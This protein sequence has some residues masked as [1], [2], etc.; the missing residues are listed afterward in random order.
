MAIVADI[1]GNSKQD[2]AV[3]AKNLTSKAPVDFTGRRIFHWSDSFASQE[4]G[5]DSTGN[6]KVP[7]GLAV[8]MEMLSRGKF[9]ADYDNI[10]G[11]MGENS[12]SCR[13]RFYT[14]VVTRKNNIDIVLIDT[15]RNDPANSKSDGDATVANILAMVKLVQSIGKEPWVITPNPPRTFAPMTATNQ[16]VRAYVNRTMNDYCNKNNVKFIDIFNSL[17]DPTLTNGAFAPGASDDTL[18]PNMKGARLM[19][20]AALLQMDALYPTTRR[21]MGVWDLYDATYNPNGN[22]LN[23]VHANAPQLLGTGGTRNNAIT[24]TLADGW[25]LNCFG[26]TATNLSVSKLAAS[27]GLDAD[28]GDAQL[29]T[30]ATTVGAWNGEFYTGFNT[31]ASLVGKSFEFEF[32]WE[33]TSWTGALPGVAA[34]L[35]PNAPGVKASA[36]NY[37][38]FATSERMLVRTA[39]AQFGALNDFMQLAIAVYAANGV[40]GTLKIVNPY[41]RIL[42]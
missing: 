5:T 17:V 32:E 28:D 11:V 22:A 24:G 1:S 23:L 31:P 35:R 9:R 20:K 34:F 41:L 30:F 2:N 40:S 14:D 42:S 37:N 8:A 10:K 13:A 4:I 29:F 39:V 15:G 16:M 26:G 19:G 33:V 7:A 21:T 6:Y 38:S 27:A 3:P 12:T 18:H 36:Q 25:F